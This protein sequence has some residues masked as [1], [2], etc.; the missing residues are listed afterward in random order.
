MGREDPRPFLYPSCAWD[1]SNPVN[2]AE[3]EGS[4]PR[5]ELGVREQPAGFLANPTS[6]SV[7]TS[8]SKAP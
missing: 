3:E 7:L 8:T 6:S 5:S 1:K 4:Q 2:P